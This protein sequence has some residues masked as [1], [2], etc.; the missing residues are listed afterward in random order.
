MWK[1]YT[2][3]GDGTARVE[4][5]YAT[6]C[7][8]WL[9]GTIALLVTGLILANP[10]LYYLA[11]GSIAAYFVFVTLPGFKVAAALRSAAKDAEITISGSRW[12]WSRPLTFVVSKGRPDA[13]DVPN[14]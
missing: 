7:S 2:V 14:A 8:Y 9:Y 6:V 13:G 12:S 1:P 5:R 4:Y 3:V 11:F 10:P